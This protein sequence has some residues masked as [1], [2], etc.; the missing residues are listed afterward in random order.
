MA[1]MGSLS[2]GVRN[3]NKPIT[4]TIIYVGSQNQNQT[5]YFG[6][7]TSSTSFGGSS[8]QGGTGWP[9]TSDRNGWKLIAFIIAAGSTN[10]SLATPTWSGRSMTLV[11]GKNDGTTTQ[12]QGIWSLDLTTT[13]IYNPQGITV[14]DSGGLANIRNV[15]VAMW[16]IKGFVSTTPYYTTST[17]SAGTTTSSHLQY[18]TSTF[19]SNPG[20]SWGIVCGTQKMLD[21]ET[22]YYNSPIASSIPQVQTYG[23]DVAGAGY[24][25]GGGTNANFRV[26]LAHWYIVNTSTNSVVGYSGHSWQ[27]TSAQNAYLYTA[28][29][30]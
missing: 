7:P 27:T 25:V 14:S 21:G 22:C 24:D 26:G 30:Q 1:R 20:N 17:T 13:D 3:R 19:L 5:T 16:L 10:F 18:N 2:A 12:P 8:M 29:F 4:R 6:A 23:P 15:T 28:L 11:S 9:S